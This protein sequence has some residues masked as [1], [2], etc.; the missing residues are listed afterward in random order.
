MVNFENICTNKKITFSMYVGLHLMIC[1]ICNIV[2]K[3]GQHEIFS[4]YDL[5]SFLKV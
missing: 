3:T 4:K 5:S 2:F 1:K